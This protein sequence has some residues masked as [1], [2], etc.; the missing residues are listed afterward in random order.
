MGLS[1]FKSCFAGL[2]FYENSLKQGGGGGG[3]LI[4]SRNFAFHNGLDLTIKID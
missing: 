2:I 4:I 3:G 1:L